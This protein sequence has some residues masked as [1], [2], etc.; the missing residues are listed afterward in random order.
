MCVLFCVCSACCVLRP[1]NRIAAI[2]QYS[3][4]SRAHNRHLLSLSLTINYPVLTVMNSKQGSMFDIHADYSA[5]SIEVC[6]LLSSL[7][8]SL[9]FLFSL[10]FS[11]FSSL[12]ILLSSLFSLYSSLYSLLSRTVRIPFTPL[13]LPLPCT[14]KSFLFTTI[15]LIFPTTFQVP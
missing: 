4:L 9:I 15:L 10:L 6:T 5:G 8:L 13:P 2:F 11:L 7:L 1:Q 14:V 12:F 3:N